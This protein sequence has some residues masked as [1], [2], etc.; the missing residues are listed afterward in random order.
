MRDEDIAVAYGF[1]AGDD[2]TAHFSKVSIENIL[3]YIVAGAIYI[4]ERFF[5]EHKK[6]V[7]V[8]IDGIIPHRPKWYRDKT[9]LF[10]KDKVLIPDT[11]KYDLTGMSDSDIEAARIVKYA[12]ATENKDASILTIKVAGENGG[13]RSKLDPETQ[14]QLSAYLFEIKDAG[15][16][17]NL[18]N[19]NP[20]VFNC[21]VDV[22]YDAMLLPEN[23]QAV[24]RDTIVHYVENL[25]FNGEYTNM[26]L[27]DALQKV[28]GVKIVEFIKATTKVDGEST[29]TE[30]NARYT[31]AAGYFQSGEL[32]I[33]MKVYE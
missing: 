8:L 32:T 7:Q 3:F 16:R 21:E 27:V 5:D 13:V 26:S 15:V 33:A 2:F 17:I 19:S 9:L 18:V 11:D 6:D 29:L 25:P 1:A 31:P 22:Y 14:V 23:V 30:I 28:E 10:M 24:C 4:V 20:D 12:V